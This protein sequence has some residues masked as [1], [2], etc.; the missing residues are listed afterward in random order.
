MQ[1]IMFVTFYSGIG[2]HSVRQKDLTLLSHTGPTDLTL[3]VMR[4]MVGIRGAK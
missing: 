4:E 1:H 2:I 3:V